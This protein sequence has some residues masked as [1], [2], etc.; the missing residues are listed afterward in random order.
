MDFPLD[1]PN[2]RISAEVFLDV[3]GRFEPDHRVGIATRSE[4][5]DGRI[6][7]R[8]FAAPTARE[9][10]SWIPE[11]WRYE[12]EV[13]ETSYWMMNPLKSAALKRGTL[14]T[15]ASGYKR[16]YVEATDDNVDALSCIAIDLDVGRP[17]LPTAG[18][19]IKGIFNAV[20][21]GIL[22]APTYV[23]ASGQGAYA[24]W[25][26]RDPDGGLPTNDGEKGT[27]RVRW[28]GVMFELIR[29]ARALELEPDGKAVNPSR[30]L[31]LPGTLDTLLVE[32]RETKSGKQVYYLPFIPAGSSSAK[33]SV[34]TFIELENFLGLVTVPA[35]PSDDRERLPVAEISAVSERWSSPALSPL[36]RSDG[37]D[38]SHRWARLAQEIAT[39]SDARGGMKE[40]ERHLAL[41]YY[42]GAL[43]SMYACRRSESRDDPY[44]LARAAT[45]ALARS[46]DPPYPSEEVE[47]AIKRPAGRS[48]S[49]WRAS[50]LARNLKVT[51]AEAEALGLHA[52]APP[53]VRE[54][55]AQ[56]QRELVGSRAEARL[57]QASDVRALILKHPRWSD[58]DIARYYGGID[59]QYVTPYRKA[60]IEEG[61]L[62]RPPRRRPSQTTMP[63]I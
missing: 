14:P 13:A 12:V 1:D 11:L 2:E 30:W 34:Y 40:G 17:G 56:K 23:A 51:R 36:K 9:V 29:L 47:G 7:P 41:F 5:R 24:I 39:L 19:A 52:I 60:L 45:Y 15:E 37:K 61:L 63:G 16:Q 33:P 3:V 25:N 35:L 20:T 22:P 38:G 62:E 26:L 53:A 42:F 4:D 27:N 58:L 49:H 6:R 28:R 21:A 8:V 50:T 18:D 43:R 57:R 44:A 48:K 31:K 10:L 54:E 46:F 55:R 32:G 59:R